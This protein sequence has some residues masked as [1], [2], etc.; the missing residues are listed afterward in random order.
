M[1]DAQS[2][3]EEADQ[4][5]QLVAS[6]HQAVYRYAYRLTGSVQDAEDMTQKVFLAAQQ[7]IGQLRKLD[8]VRNW[9]FAILRNC[10]LKD[11]QRRWPVLAGDLS[12]NMDSLPGLTPDDEPD[13]DQLQSALN[14]L[15][16]DARLA[17]VMFYME[18]CSYREIA[19]GLEMPIGTVMSRLARARDQLRSLLLPDSERENIRKR[20]PSAVAE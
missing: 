12:L 4:I 18:G 5:A 19:E 2:W 10:F 8:S 7:K 6:H 1:A 16:D 17:V 20:R 3:A 15:T 13:Y 14:Q 11:R 9:L